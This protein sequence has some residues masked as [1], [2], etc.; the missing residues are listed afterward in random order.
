MKNK[1][2]I[3]IEWVKLKITLYIDEMKTSMMIS[4]KLKLFK[5]I[6]SM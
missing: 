6:T 3:Y 1:D 4:N 5:I 2:N